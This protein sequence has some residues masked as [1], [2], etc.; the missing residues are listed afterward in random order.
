NLLRKGVPASRVLAVTFTNKAAAEMRARVRALVPKSDLAGMVISTFH[1]L[2]IRLLRADAA[3][4][5]WKTNFTIYD[6][7]D[8][9]S[10]LRGVLRE[11]RLGEIE[12]PIK[13][14]RWQV[15]DAKNRRQRRML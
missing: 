10:L 2:G 1:S 6:E 9:I 5:G 11:L 7:S 15:S 8:Q 14:I 4:L 12:A 13:R 3:R